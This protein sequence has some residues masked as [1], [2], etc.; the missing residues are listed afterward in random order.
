M[1]AV[2]GAFAKL[3][4]ATTSFVMVRQTYL[5]VT[6]I[7]TLPVMSLSSLQHLLEHSSQSPSCECEVAEYHFYRQL[8]RP[9]FVMCASRFVVTSD[10]D[11]QCF[12]ANCCLS[13]QGVLK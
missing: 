11:F 2:L 5:N 6:F 13:F 3:R 8:A 1:Q 4:I 9:A 7:R 10:M 12:G